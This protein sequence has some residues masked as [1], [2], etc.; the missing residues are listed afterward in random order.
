M[1]GIGFQVALICFDLVF[2]KLKGEKLICEC[3]E[4][5]TNSKGLINK[6]NFKLFDTYTTISIYDNLE[7]VIECYEIYKEDYLN[8]INTY[9]ESHKKHPLKI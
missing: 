1:V 6:H 7:H 3:M 9:N 4:N 8:F 5:N 2:N